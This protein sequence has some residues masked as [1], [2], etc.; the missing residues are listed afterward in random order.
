MPGMIGQCNAHLADGRVCRA[1][2]TALDRQRGG[3][4]CPDCHRRRV[5]DDHVALIRAVARLAPTPAHLRAD[6]RATLDRLALDT[7]D[8]PEGSPF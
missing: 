3:L 8:E 7:S 2:A 1:P 4:I 6:A 5:L